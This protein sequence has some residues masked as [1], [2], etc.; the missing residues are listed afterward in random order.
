VRLG[1]GVVVLVLVGFTPRI[2]SACGFSPYSDQAERNDAA[3]QVLLRGERL[4]ILSPGWHSEYW[5]LAWARVHGKRFD[6]DEARAFTDDLDWL[7]LS[8]WPAVSHAIDRWIEAQR[9]HV[10]RAAPRPEPARRRGDYGHDLVCGPDAFLTAAETLHRLSGGLSPSE[11][12]A[13]AVAQNAVFARCSD[14]LAPIPDELPDTAPAYARYDRAYQ[15]AAAMDY[16]GDANAAIDA[17][18]A[19]A[20]SPSP[21]ADI[22]RYRAAL[23]R[24]RGGSTGL[25][26]RPCGRPRRPIAGAT[27]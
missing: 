15:R 12:S 24:V 22:A 25:H 27:P 2:A 21:W 3:L 5:V 20:R 1:L 16:G 18:D 17:F 4:P 6:D 13:W 26:R 9:A 7:R 23:S 8:P 19:I 11:V 10:G 14:P